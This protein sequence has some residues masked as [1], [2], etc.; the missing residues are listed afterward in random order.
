[1]AKAS[2]RQ[3]PNPPN[4][5]ARVLPEPHAFLPASFDRADVAAGHLTAAG[6]WLYLNQKFCDICGFLP[7]EL[8]LLDPAALEHPEE[9]FWKD[10]CARVRAGAVAHASAETRFVRGDGR[11]VWVHVIATPVRVDPAAPAET[12]VLVVDTTQR[13]R[14]EQRFTA[15]FAV[16]EVL[17]DAPAPGIDAPKV[18][19]ALCESLSWEIGVFWAPSETP[20]VLRCEATW[21]SSRTAALL[22]F[23]SASRSRTLSKGDGAAGT[24]WV[25]GEPVMLH[26]L[27]TTS[28]FGR[29]GEALN[30]GLGAA[31]A[32]PVFS[33]DE[34]FGVMEFFSRAAYAEEDLQELRDTVGLIAQELS[35]STTRYHAEAAAREGELR[36]TAIVDS[37]LDC[38]ITIDESGIITEFNEAAELTFGFTRADVIGTELTKTIIPAS[39]RDV[40]IAGVARHLTE[41]AGQA[42][43][44]RIETT[45]MRAN[46]EEFPIELTVMRMPLPGP[47]VF[48]AFIRDISERYES[49]RELQESNDRYRRLSELAQEG[50]LLH[51]AGKL[52]D[53]NETYLRMFGYKLHELKGKYILDFMIAPESRSITR[54]NARSGFELPFEIVARRKDGTTFPAEIKGRAAT[55]EGRNVRVA[56]VRDITERRELERQEQRLLL[57]RAARAEAEEQH[58]KMEFLAEA[59]R[60]LGTSFD[61]NTTIAQLVRL[62]VPAFADWCDVDAIEEDGSFT[63]L[64]YAHMDPKKEAVLGSLVQLQLGLARG[65]HPI[66]HVINTGE[67]VYV[68]DVPP[69]LT[70]SFA[71]DDA[72][73][74]VLRAL[75]PRSAIIVPLVV[76][77]RVYAAMTLAMS[78][79]GRR[80]NERDLAMAETLARRAALA[81]QHARLYQQAEQATQARDEMLGVVAHD[82]RNP[83]NTIVMGADLLSELMGSRKSV[84]ETRQ[85]E[86]LQRAANRMNRM[87]QDLLDVRRMDT[88]GLVIEARSESVSNLMAD[89]VDMLSPLAA[90]SS[91][92]LRI[93]STDGLT[94]VFVDPA[95]IQQVF[96]NLVG[97]ALKFTPPNG[98]VELCALAVGAEVQFSVIDTGPGIAPEQ[99]P[100]VF[101]RFFQA[102]KRDRRGIGLGLT[103]AQAIVEGHGGRI[104]VESK[105]GRGST[106]RFTVPT[107][108]AGAAL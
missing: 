82:L 99:L 84:M 63:R 59:S 37:A 100:H 23:A 93:C 21:S 75:D 8:L 6:D 34:L 91:I 41:G 54:T 32:F 69:G 51:E 31:L 87:I 98:C 46:G 108:H 96:S 106:F 12:M 56:T 77:E 62:M 102:D 81:I 9:T 30:A 26:D 79:S 36:K 55:F 50:L 18:L 72:H 57:E 105:V 28:T 1:M 52:L 7:D 38:I 103:I 74:E 76:G 43:G 73:R 44:E 94:P 25:L 107:I 40:H 16:S 48:T 2:M 15:E 11:L 71:T 5:L 88:S 86:I 66:M 49:R 58:R 60:V 14:R 80:F 97:N 53:A 92:E 83:L 78:E 13:R 42:S 20:G 39:M 47:A 10:L 27:T 3:N 4:P 17:G 67:T 104:W 33:G 35:L 24:S 85:L 95:R 61:Y 64:G 101:R 65:N 22:R 29:N 68:P 90:A 45:G 19:E 89:A 70:D